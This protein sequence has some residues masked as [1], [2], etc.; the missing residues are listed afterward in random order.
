FIDSGISCEKVSVLPDAVDIERFNDDIKPLTLFTG[1]RNRSCF[2]F[3][4][5]F[6]WVLKKGWD[7]LIE[8]YVKEFDRQ[9]DVC[10]FI[11]T[12]SY[13]GMPIG[14]IKEI[15]YETIKK[16]TKKHS[17]NIPGIIILEKILSQD[18]MP[19]LYSSCD[20]FVLPSRGEGW[21]RPYMEAM[22]SGVSVIGTGYGG[23]TDFMNDSNS[24][25]IDYKLE[26][27]PEQGIIEYPDAS[28]KKWAEPSCEHL[29]YLMRF[30]YENRICAKEKARKAR[31]KMRIY[32]NTGKI[33]KKF[34]FELESLKDLD[35]K[36][37]KLI[38][39]ENDVKNL[40]NFFNK[41]NA[42]EDL[43]KSDFF[44]F[45]ILS[46]G[47]SC[48][49]CIFDESVC[50][51][52]NIFVLKFIDNLNPELDPDDEL[53]KISV[54]CF[55]NIV[56]INGRNPVTDIFYADT[57]K[58]NCFAMTINILSNR[59]D[60]I[61]VNNRG[62]LEL[63]LKNGFCRENL[64]YIDK[65]NS[66]GDEKLPEYLRDVL[67]KI[68]RFPVKKNLNFQHF[69]LVRKDSLNIE[70]LKDSKGIVFIDSHK[71]SDFKG[72]FKSYVENNLSKPDSML[73]IYTNPG[74]ASTVFAELSNIVKNLEY[75]EESIPDILILDEV[76]T[77]ADIDRLVASAS[78][79]IPADSSLNTQ[80]LLSSARFSVKIKD[81]KKEILS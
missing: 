40:N 80:F 33:A 63:L 17:E 2:K 20:C 77:S 18:E 15:I 21:G 25:L 73:M 37:F 19:G 53:M 48:S 46:N 70:N 42:C 54:S 69:N 57:G 10:L 26:P 68:K 38:I 51:F 79:Y 7:V 62:M 24:F 6:D 74:K 3:L 64:A 78:F 1:T 16:K 67:L 61:I 45:E 4:S 8:A 30:V 35:K 75:A 32:F 22:A 9:E 23:N 14:K 65:E 28:G 27:V 50:R 60:L 43:N 41:E 58:L 44:S 11:K 47:K 71:V 81:Y 12:F 72:T 66:T 13:L 29:M 59:A 34:I 36:I 31:E 39:K 56:F 76:L 55:H 5:V 52:N 49:P